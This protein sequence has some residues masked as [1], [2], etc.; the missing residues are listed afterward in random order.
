MTNIARRLDLDADM[1][2]LRLHQLVPPL[3]RCTVLHT[4]HRTYRP[5]TRRRTLQHYVSLLREDS[6][7][8]N[9]QTKQRIEAKQ[10]SKQTSKAKRKASEHF[11][12]NTTWFTNKRT[13]TKVSLRARSAA[14]AAGPAA[15]TVPVLSS[16]GLVPLAV[17]LASRAGPPSA[18]PWATAPSLL[19][20][21][22]KGPGEVTGHRQSSRWVE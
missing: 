14:G 7:T 4:P 3:P 1:P 13:N 10:R 16:D 21:S 17:L 5:R 11:K 19:H 20:A 9:E 2:A 6:A 18:A 12:A 8:A 22:A 15:F